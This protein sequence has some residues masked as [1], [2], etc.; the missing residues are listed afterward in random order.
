MYVC[1]MYGLNQYSTNLM[2][3]QSAPIFD[4]LPNGIYV[5]IPIVE[6]CKIYWVQVEDKGGAIVCRYTVDEQEAATW[7]Q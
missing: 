7:I 1:K 2:F 5:V 4:D 3:S 6:T